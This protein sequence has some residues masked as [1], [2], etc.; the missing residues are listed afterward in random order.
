MWRFSCYTRYIDYH[1]VKKA[2]WVED[3]TY[4]VEF[5]YCILYTTPYYHL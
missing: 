5:G 4:Y 2:E 3:G 1:I